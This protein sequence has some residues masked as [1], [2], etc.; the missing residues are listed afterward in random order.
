MELIVATF[1]TA[2]MTSVLAGGFVLLRDHI[3]ARSE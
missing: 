2:V 3:R 1:A